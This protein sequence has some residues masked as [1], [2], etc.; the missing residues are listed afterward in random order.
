MITQSLDTHPEIEK[1]QIAV[2]PV[3]NAFEQL[4][5]YLLNIF[6]TGLR[7][8]MRESTRAELILSL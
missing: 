6:S 1:V 3:A 4:G 7:S 2:E 5:V 8:W